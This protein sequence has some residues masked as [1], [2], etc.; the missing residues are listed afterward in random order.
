MKKD[1][2]TKVAFKKIPAVQK[3]APDLL[4]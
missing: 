2:M 3:T 1:L 4:G